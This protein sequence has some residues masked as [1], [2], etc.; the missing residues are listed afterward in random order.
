MIHP[1]PMLRV[2]FKTCQFRMWRCPKI[3]APNHPVVM[4]DHDFVLQQPWYHGYH[5]DAFL[6]FSILGTKCFMAYPLVN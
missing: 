6:F 2:C 1:R 4:D 3:K 5:G